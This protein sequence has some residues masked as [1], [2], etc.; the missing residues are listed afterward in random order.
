MDRA[1]EGTIA[2][3]GASGKTGREVI[4]SAI[5]QGVRVKALY[6]P[7]SEP[8]TPSRGLEVVTGQLTNP[9][10][11]RRALQGTDGAILVFGPRLSRKVHGDVFCA[12]AT[13]TVIREMKGLG[14]RRLVCQTGAMAGGDSPNWSWAVRGFVRRYRRNFPEVDADRDAQEAE[15]KASGLDW[16]VAKPFRIS[17]AKGKGHVRAAPNLR[18]GMF[19]STRRADLADFLVAEVRAGRF[20]GQAIYVLT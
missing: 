14:I 7:G 18:I 16:T 19:T 12:A 2:V 5:R 15:V 11:V 13:A 8:A 17:G 20:P 4:A 1:T 3:F 9:D 6:R 10:D